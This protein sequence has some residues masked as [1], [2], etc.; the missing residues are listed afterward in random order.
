SKV[1]LTFETVNEKDVFGFAVLR[2]E[3]KEGEYA[4]VASAYETE[5]LKASGTSN[6]SVTYNF[7]DQSVT[8][9][10]TY[11]YKIVSID[12]DGS[13]TVHALIA[14][15]TP[16]APERFAILGNYPNPFSRTNHA[17]TSIA[18]SVPSRSD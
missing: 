12:R 4:Q 16:M 8:N 14:E 11:Y 5:S 15:A 9:G 2:S 6:Q 1:S 17:T 3:L 18:F 7:M 13:R 10:T